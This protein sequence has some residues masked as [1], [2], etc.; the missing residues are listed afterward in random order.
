MSKLSELAARLEAPKMLGQVDE[1]NTLCVSP[2]DENIKAAAA[3]REAEQ[4]LR[5]CDKRIKRRIS[6]PLKDCIRAMIE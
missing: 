1:N 2:S 6:D 5:E 3:L 4:V